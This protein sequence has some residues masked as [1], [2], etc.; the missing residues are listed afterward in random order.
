MLLSSGT[1]C[2]VLANV[3]PECSLR[4]VTFCRAVAVRRKVRARC[5][6]MWEG[7]RKKCLSSL[8]WVS[9]VFLPQPLRVLLCARSWILNTE[10]LFQVSFCS[11]CWSALLEKDWQFS[12]CQCSSLA[13]L[14]QWSSGAESHVQVKLLNLHTN[15]WH[16]SQ[17]G[18]YLHLGFRAT[19]DNDQ[20]ASGWQKWD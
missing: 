5:S 15:Y 2:Y 10:P 20:M 3:R 17:Q 13:L 14:A 4:Q 7:W 1:D 18:W 8:S 6:T 9:V 19:L 11:L 12:S 16:L